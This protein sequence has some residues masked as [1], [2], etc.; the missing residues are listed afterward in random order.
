MIKTNHWQHLVDTGEVSTSTSKTTFEILFGGPESSS[1]TGNAGKLG[2]SIRPTAGTPIT[3][4]WSNPAVF[5]TDIE[6]EW[7]YYV[8]IVTDNTVKLYFDANEVLT[9]AYD[10]TNMVMNDLTLSGYVG[11]Y[12]SGTEHERNVLISDLYIGEYNPNV[13][14]PEFIQELYNAKKPFAVPAKMPII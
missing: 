14:T 7:H 3:R 13:W 10:P 4:Y 1:G 9:G 11:N 12:D 8:C 2:I 6:K 5:S